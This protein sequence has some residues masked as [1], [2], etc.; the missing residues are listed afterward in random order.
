V[1]PFPISVAYDAAA[2]KRTDADR[3]KELRE[4]LLKGIGVASEYLGVGVD[5]V[6]YTKGIPER[7]RAIE[8]FFEKYPEFVE[9]FTFVE[10]GAPSRTHIKRYRELTTEV[11]EM[12]DSI[13]WRFQNKSWKPVVF[14]KA[15]HG[16]EQINRFYKSADVCMVTSLHD[17]MNLVAKEF[18]AS[19]DDDDGVLILSRFT[20]ACRELRDAVIVNPYDIEEMADAIHLSLTMDSQEKEERMSR[21]RST[22]KEH[23]IYRWAGNLVSSLSRLR[24]PEEINGNVPK[25]E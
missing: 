14:L 17:G 11:E 18:V 3:K 1:K 6:D 10:L 21:L 20:G 19:R 5:R 25:K 15:H 22:V 23:N 8:R 13:N 2:E 9:R 16:H 4:S 12:A 24:L 7:L